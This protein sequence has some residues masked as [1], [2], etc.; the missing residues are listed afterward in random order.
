MYHALDG[1]RLTEVKTMKELFLGPP[2]GGRGRLIEVKFTKFPILFYNYFGA[3][4]TG[5]LTE[6][7]A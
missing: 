3:L 4:V 2:K 7:G 5:R 1:H 6:G